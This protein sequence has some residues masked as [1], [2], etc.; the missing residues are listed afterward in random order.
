MNRRL[1]SHIETLEAALEDAGAAPV[2][3]RPPT[4]GGDAMARV[5]QVLQTKDAEI[6]ALLRLA[7]EREK[8][9]HR[10]NAQLAHRRPTDTLESNASFVL[11]RCESLA[12]NGSFSPSAVVMPGAPIEPFVEVIR[13]LRLQCANLQTQLLETANHGKEVL[14]IDD[15]GDVLS[16]RDVL[17]E[18]DAELLLKD[19]LLLQRAT[20]VDALAQTIALL[21][22]Q[23]EQLGEE[24]VCR[25]PQEQREII[26]QQLNDTV[27]AMKLR[28]AELEAEV[29]AQQAEKAKV[30]SL[31]A[32]MNSDR[33]KEAAVFA[34]TREGLEKRVAEGVSAGDQ[35]E[36]DVTEKLERVTGDREDSEKAMREQLRDNTRRMM[37]AQAA[38]A[39]EQVARDSDSFF[40]RFK[41]RF[42]N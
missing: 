27:A 8:E 31:L 19:E 1:Q 12:P 18:K 34:S 42:N 13:K 10:A 21:E 20:D 37:D 9:L 22:R 7:Q 30:A 4:D 35:R 26:E 11:G 15:D 25:L 14:V 39:E 17:A 36:R 16:L 23:I 6:D 2:D 29:A 33:K 38:L 41:R 5:R 28:E 3:G 24:P 32:S 40:G